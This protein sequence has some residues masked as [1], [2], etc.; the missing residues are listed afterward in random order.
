MPLEKD[1][2][3]SSSKRSRVACIRAIELRHFCLLF[4]IGS[5]F[6]TFRHLEQWYNGAMRQQSGATHS[7]ISAHKV[8]ALSDEKLTIVVAHCR[9]D[10]TW[11]NQYGS[12][13]AIAG[14]HVMSKCGMDSIPLP[15]KVANCTFIHHILNCGVEEYAY[16]HYIEQNYDN[17]P[18]MIAFVTGGSLS[19]NPHLIHDSLNFLN[20]TMYKDL[21]RYVSTAWHMG[22]TVDGEQFIW[23]MT[24]PEV[25]DQPHWLANWRSHFLVSSS[26]IQRY[27]RYVYSNVTST[28]CAKK[29]HE[30]NCNFEVMYNTFFRCV[31]FLRPSNECKEHKIYA[32]PRVDYV[33]FWKDGVAEHAFMKTTTLETTL[34]TCGNWTML[35]AESNVNGVLMCVERQ[36]SAMQNKLFDWEMAMNMMFAEKE[37]PQVEQIQ[38]AWKVE[39]VVTQNRPPQWDDR[40]DFDRAAEGI[41]Q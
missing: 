21:A 34:L 36:E 39:E 18:P 13:D 40:E 1:S 41:L 12:C 26:Q 3:R 4:I 28:I 38:W 5:S 35:T 29:C 37:R 24:T 16:M 19:E 9:E 11:L 6:W 7:D 17:L 23:N 15:E 20:G 32:V 31:P 10:I 22:S 33:D 25:W 30:E 27:P 8:E 14:I 2:G